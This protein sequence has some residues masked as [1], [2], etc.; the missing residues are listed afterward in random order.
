MIKHIHIVSINRHGGSLLARLLD[1]H[2]DVASY[3]LENGFPK[4][5]KIHNFV[6]F[7]NGSPTYV[8]DFKDYKNNICKFLEIA[9]KKNKIIHK[10]GKEKSD[11]VGIRKNYLEKA[12]YQNVK[13]DFDYAKYISLIK[14]SDLDVKSVHEIYDTMHT[15][16]FNSW[17]NG[18]HKGNLKFVVMQSSGGLFLK[19]FDKY[20]GEFKDSFILCPIRDIKTYIAS[21]KARLARLYFG[22]RRFQSPKVPN[23]LVK[24][25]DMYDLEAQ[26]RTW[27][28]AF[29]R[30][31]ILQEKYGLDGK[32]IVYR[33]ENLVN[34]TS[35]VMKSFCNKM[36][37]KFDPILLKPTIGGLNWLGNSHSGKQTGIN[38]SNYYKEVL[39]EDELNL[40]K[41]KSLKLTEFLD[42]DKN[43]PLDLSKV[44]KN[45]L[46][47]YDIQS[48]FSKNE[49]IWAIYSA[50]AFRGYRSVR[51]K[52]VGWIAIIAFLFSKFIYL[53]NIPRLIK[54]RIFPGLGKQNYT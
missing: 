3:P 19:S 5:F 21:E 8:P 29:T 39:R 48:E 35:N 40:I 30:L 45:F 17:D 12:F 52:K 11:P 27:L 46:Y 54:L 41:K 37:L 33:Y 6:D 9:E 50:F 10:W 14:K 49:R 1:N 13:T 42:S 15:A 24:A 22:S 20:F 4:D 23:F 2:P 31:V 32:F 26:I 43:T 16:Y 36:N 25:F 38:L 28:V 44:S 18:S 7:L 53:A 47:D 34:D 51:V